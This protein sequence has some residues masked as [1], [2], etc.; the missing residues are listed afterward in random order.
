M[1][2]IADTCAHVVRVTVVA[3]AVLAHFILGAEIPIVELKGITMRPGYECYDPA[4]GALY[5]KG[6]FITNLYTYGQQEH[7]LVKLVHEFFSRGVGGNFRTTNSYAK[8]AHYLTARDLGRIIG[9]IA[10]YEG[11]SSTMPAGHSVGSAG[12]SSGVPVAGT[13]G[14]GAERVTEAKDRLIVSIKKCIDERMRDAEKNINDEILHGMAE[15]VMRNKGFRNQALERLYEL[16][17]RW[18]S[19]A[20]GRADAIAMLEKVRESVQTRGN[21]PSES[22]GLADKK[23]WWSA[24]ERLLNFD[25]A[26]HAVYSTLKSYDDRVV[27]DAGELKRLRDAK[28]QGA[29]GV[30]YKPLQKS[31]HN[32]SEI[33]ADAVDE[34]QHGLYPRTTVVSTLLGWLWGNFSSRQDCGAYLEGLAEAVNAN[35][36]DVAIVEGDPTQSMRYS[37]SDYL[38]L[39][40]LDLGKIDQLRLADYVL[41][42]YGYDLYP[43]NN[44]PPDFDFGT[45]VHTCTAGGKTVRFPFS[46]CVETALRKFINAIIYDPD[47][48]TFDTQLLRSFGATEPLLKFY[49]EKYSNA[50]TCTSAEARNAWADVV[51]DLD[52]IVYGV[53]EFKCNIRSEVPN[54]LAVIKKLLPRTRTTSFQ[55]LIQTLRDCGVEILIMKDEVARNG[56]LELVLT[57]GGRENLLSW[58]ISEGHTTLRYPNPATSAEYLVNYGRALELRSANVTGNAATTT[59]NACNVMPLMVAYASFSPSWPGIFKL[60]GKLVDRGI[61]TNLESFLFLLPAQSAQEKASLAAAA[62]H[63]ALSSDCVGDDK[64]ALRIV[65]SII[66]D[67]PV[68]V[69]AVNE[70]CGTIFKRSALADAIEAGKLTPRATSF[71]LSLLETLTKHIQEKFQGMGQAEPLLALIRSIGHGRG[72]EGSGPVSSLVQKIHA[73]AI[74]TV[75]TSVLKNGSDE[76]NRKLSSTNKAEFYRMFR[77]LPKISN[78]ALKCLSMLLESIQEKYE[79]YDVFLDL[80]P[81]QD[82]RIFDALKNH[83]GKLSEVLISGD[84][85]EDAV[86]HLLSRNIENA[87]ERE[88]IR[89]F[90]EALEHHFSDMIASLMNGS[91]V[92][93]MRE[94]RA[95]YTLV[96]ALKVANAMPYAYTSTQQYQ[97]HGQAMQEDLLKSIEHHLGALI[98]FCASKKPGLMAVA[99]QALSGAGPTATA[100]AARL[101]ND[102]TSHVLFAL[103]KLQD[104]GAW[105]DVMH[106]VFVAS[107]KPPRLPTFNAEV[108]KKYVK[109]TQNLPEPVSITPDT[110]V[111]I[112]S[113]I[114]AGVELGVEEP[115]R[116]YI[117]SIE[118]NLA[119]NYWPR[120]VYQGLWLVYEPYTADDKFGVNAR[121]FALLEPLYDTLHTRVAIPSIATGIYKEIST[122]EKQIFPPRYEPARAKFFKIYETIA[123]VVAAEYMK[124]F[125]GNDQEKD[126]KRRQFKENFMQQIHTEG[127]L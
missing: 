124:F 22:V 117:K 1:A 115:L 81:P 82:L 92:Q 30:H 14:G 50:E 36:R 39:E 80:F 87:Q 105:N 7:A 6:N 8:I 48:R 26:S 17:L 46:D 51:S 40:K 10:V 59:I 58:Y 127:N 37:R 76:F 101:L 65:S 54:I 73:D 125:S 98:D 110:I 119:R 24:L 64:R 53:E 16:V 120:T 112:P 71:T 123:E 49:E 11:G 104:T 25:E 113:I 78:D 63:Y 5:E 66:G 9:A 70:F 99:C 42:R 35:P 88:H 43:H 68:D 41:A 93:E 109:F 67:L 122:S 107:K 108:L 95:Y 15:T 85:L 126:A 97:G 72:I 84:T 94:T 4:V 19:N 27:R 60:A 100:G 75:I 74:S 2:K 33:I 55:D 102:L 29:I 56:E 18:A 20:P 21:E 52:G 61:A 62:A 103:D 83:I 13:A 79:I 91:L 28:N 47:K 114:R 23:S 111:F 34:E 116:E 106:T 45:A 12:S 32:L 86:T 57:K 90:Y 121:V 69:G 3:I 118:H 44:L 31:A 38:A 89:V 77:T 96:A